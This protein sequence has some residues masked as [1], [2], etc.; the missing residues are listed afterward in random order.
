EE[1]IQNEVLDKKEEM[2]TKS[3][4]E[5]TIIKSEKANAK[6]EN[7]TLNETKKETSNNEVNNTTNSST[8]KQE[9]KIEEETKIEEQ[10]KTYVNVKRSNG[11]VLTLEL[12]EYVVGVVAAEMP[13]AFHEQALMAQS[14][15]ARTYALK[16]IQKGQV[17][18]DNE[19]TQSY[20]SN[21]ELKLK[22]GSSY[23]T[24]YNKIKNAV[25]STEGIYLTFNGTYIEAVYHS[26]S[27]G[28]TEDSSNVWGNSFPYLV[29]VESEYDSLNPSFIS[30]K[31]ITYQE[32]SSKLG[33]DINTDTE[34]NIISKTSGNRVETLQI[35]GKDYNGVQ[36][37]NLLALRSAD[38][39][40]TKTDTGITF[41]TRGYGHG[42]GLSQ[43]GANGM[44][45]AGYSYE[46][47]LKHYYKG[48][49]INH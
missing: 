22:W 7:T 32:L 20:K 33:I 26:T 3:I 30:E 37:R 44:A 46:Q 47:I 39:D 36:F 4:E 13:A 15:I 24:Y 12:E 34:F 9:N 40:I 42:V 31:T 14:V 8:T 23:N 35:D 21:D 17:L 25:S 29:S 11:Q 6:N 45:K 28:R 27:N 49:T 18:T 1:N 10:N 48:V 5:S 19:S 38:F 2:S 41:T 43:Y 16:A